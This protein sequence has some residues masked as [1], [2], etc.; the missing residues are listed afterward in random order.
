M[1]VS[2]NFIALVADKHHN[3]KRIKTG[4]HILVIKKTDTKI[5]K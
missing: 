2:S 3:K 1:H 4:V 5:S